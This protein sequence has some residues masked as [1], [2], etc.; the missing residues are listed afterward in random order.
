MLQKVMGRAGARDRQLYQSAPRRL[1]S[2]ETERALR[3]SVEARQRSV[4]V[5]GEAA[6]SEAR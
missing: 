6:S 3:A 4:S 5:R 2:A 1:K